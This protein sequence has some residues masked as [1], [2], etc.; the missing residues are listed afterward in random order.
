V[1]TLT[2][3]LATQSSTSL[4]CRG[5]ATL[6]L[7]GPARRFSPGADGWVFKAPFPVRLEREADDTL[8][9]VDELFGNYGHGDSYDS[10]V[11]DL[12]VTLTE[13]YRI[14][15]G[16]EDAASR[17]IFDDLRSYLAPRP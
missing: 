1:S 2:V 15:E 5:A 6:A 7:L 9:A 12:A 11:G 16:C 17:E 13:Y 4:E 8:I 14:M 3:S 10:A